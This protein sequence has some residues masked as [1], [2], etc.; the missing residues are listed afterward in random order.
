MANVTNYGT[1]LSAI[2]PALPPD[3]PSVV[4]NGIAEGSNHS[5]ILPTSTIAGQDLTYAPPAFSLDGKYVFCCR[6]DAVRVFVKATGAVLRD[7]RGH[8]NTVTS[9]CLHPK[10]RFQIFSTSLDNS[11]IL[12]DFE[13]GLL[14]NRFDLDLKALATV[15][16]GPFNV[17]RLH[18][19][20]LPHGVTEDGKETGAPSAFLLVRPQKRPDK[21]PHLTLLRGVMPAP[22]APAF[23]FDTFAIGRRSIGDPYSVDFGCDGRLAV[24][25]KGKK[26]GVYDTKKREFLMHYNKT[27]E[28]I[29]VACHPHLPL[30]VVGCANG[31]ILAINEID[32]PHVTRVVYHWHSLPVT[33]LAFTKDGTHFLSGGHEC[34][35]VR[36]NLHAAGDRKYV[37]RVGAA[38]RR[39]AISASNDFYAVSLSDNSVAVYGSTRV[40]EAV[41]RGMIKC[42]FKRA[43]DDGFANNNSADITNKNHNVDVDVPTAVRLSAV[44]TGL[45]LDPRSN[46]LVLNGRLGH[47]QFYDLTQD[48]CLQSLDILNLNFVSPDSLDGGQ[49]LAEVKL[50][51]FDG[52]GEWL[53][54]VEQWKTV[55]IS[56]QLRLKVWRRQ[57]GSTATPGGSFALHT[58]INKPHSDEITQI[59]FRPYGEFFQEAPAIFGTT[60]RDGKFKIW[61]FEEAEVEEEDDVD[62]ENDISKRENTSRW[63]NDL[64][65]TFHNQTPMDLDFSEDGSVVGVAFGKYL[66]LWTTEFGELKDNHTNPD[67]TDSSALRQLLFGRGDSSHLVVYATRR[68]L[69]V[70]DVLTLSVSWFQDISVARLVRDPAS[71][72]MVAFEETRQEKEEK[73][74]TIFVFKPSSKTLVDLVQLGPF[75]GHGIESISALF[76]PRLAGNASSSISSPAWLRRS[77]LVFLNDRQE[78]VEVGAGVD[79]KEETVEAEEDDVDVVGGVRV[80][81]LEQQ[82]LFGALMMAE[83]RRTDVVAPAI[84]DLSTS[85]VGMPTRAFLNGPL[86]T[87]AHVLPHVS[88]LCRQMQSMILGKRD[89]GETGKDGIG[90]SSSESAVVTEAEV[91]E[92]SGPDTEAEVEEES[93]PFD[94]REVKST[95]LGNDK[96]AYWDDVLSRTSVADLSWL[97]K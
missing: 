94:K 10:N 79:S 23:V 75:S 27:D 61:S 21:T 85:T 9:V 56:Q 87:P 84:A 5:S 20:Y 28:M 64:T 77:R 97:K 74:S 45:H 91:E 73:A 19:L 40:P 95:T 57:G 32:Q 76:L 50:I 71:S 42:P 53:V 11:I 43:P 44:P 34:V 33:A 89:E 52:R 62:E 72:F 60:G 63:S 30:V 2:P 58:A 69:I 68:S 22:H 1:D 14:L 16:H 41:F 54:T 78:L 66:T 65:A 12:W 18:G 81:R 59:S 3:P 17:A 93:G 35:L 90:K 51:A 25:I 26:L 46:C 37:P 88:T 83:E 4:V 92:E 70:Y 29:S 31:K 13:D 7:L 8:R 39:I 55:E 82:T 96:T 6:G 24:S 67:K 36:W 86:A 80:K 47:L 49:I 15:K 48:R 38:I